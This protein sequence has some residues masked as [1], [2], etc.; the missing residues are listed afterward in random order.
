MSDEKMRTVAAT[1]VTPE[2]VA[3]HGLTPEEYQKIIKILGREP[4]YT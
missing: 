3:G 1:A 2:L 4:N